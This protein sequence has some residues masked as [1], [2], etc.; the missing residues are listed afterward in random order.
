M[1][2]NQFSMN[3]N[4]NFPQGNTQMPMQAQPVMQNANIIFSRPD[5]A[6][7]R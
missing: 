3:Q 4:Y 2:W 1:A 6:V 7:T 5:L